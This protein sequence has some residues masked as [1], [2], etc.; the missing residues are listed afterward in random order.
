MLLIELCYNKKGRN[1]NNLDK[2]D[3]L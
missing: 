1:F 3:L 2:P